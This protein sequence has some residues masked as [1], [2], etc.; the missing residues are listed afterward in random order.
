ML[1]KV[2]SLII[3]L[4][5]FVFNVIYKIIFISHGDICMDEPFTIF[6]A[7]GSI[8][9][10]YAMLF[11]ENNPPLF[12]VLTKAMVKMGG[13]EPFIVRFLPMLFSSLTSII[14]YKIGQRNFHFSVGLFAALFFTFSNLNIYS[15]IKF[16]IPIHLLVCL[17]A[18]ISP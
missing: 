15:G 5:L 3:P 6:Y 10:I 2:E 13:I 18:D 16:L 17:Y 8:K 11:N 9:D 1:K 12:F 14:I 4:L 7:Q